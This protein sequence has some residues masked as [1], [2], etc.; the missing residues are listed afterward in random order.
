MEKMFSHLNVICG[1]VGGPNG[2]IVHYIQHTDLNSQQS[3]ARSSDERRTNGRTEGF[4]L[5]TE[6]NMSG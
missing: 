5:T 4:P 2:P 6:G 1:C 3:K